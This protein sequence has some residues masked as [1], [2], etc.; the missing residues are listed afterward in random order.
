MVGKSDGYLAV[1]LSADDRM[2][3]DLTTACYYNQ[4][5]GEVGI[6]VTIW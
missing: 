5:N 2:G 6:Q 3:G 4:N 1:G